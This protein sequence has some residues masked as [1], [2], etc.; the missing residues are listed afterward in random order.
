[1]N[2]SRVCPRLT[3]CAQVEVLVAVQL[4]GEPGRVNVKPNVMLKGPVSAT[5]K[6]WTPPEVNANASSNNVAT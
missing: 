5:V 1:M 3:S 6:G 2:F 4:P